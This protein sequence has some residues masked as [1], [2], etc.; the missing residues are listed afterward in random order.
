MGFSRLIRPVARA[1]EREGDTMPGDRDA[2][3]EL[4]QILR[5]DL[6]ADFDRA[7]HALRWR[8]GRELIGVRAVERVSPQQHALAAGVEIRAGIGDLADWQIGVTDAAED[9][10]I[11]LPEPPRELQPE[12][13]RGRVGNRVDRHLHRRGY[14]YGRL[15]QNAER[16]GADAP[17]GPRLPHRSAGGKVLEGD[18]DAA[19]VL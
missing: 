3:L 4:G 6:S 11:L 16:Q 9:V 1:A 10:L 13:H 14:V 17:V 18:S 2:I 15:A 5:M 8:H 12:L 7:L 19:V